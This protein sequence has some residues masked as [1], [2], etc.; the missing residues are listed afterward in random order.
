MTNQEARDRAARLGLS[1]WTVQAV[2]VGASSHTVD[3]MCVGF[4]SIELP[5][6][7]AESWEEALSEAARI[8]FGA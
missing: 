6:A 8:I 1:T 4:A 2:A 3:L 7:E 5:V